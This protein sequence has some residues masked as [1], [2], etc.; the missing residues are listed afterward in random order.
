MRNV[1]KRKLAKHAC[2]SS[3]RRRRCRRGPRRKRRCGH[4]RPGPAV[5][6]G[7]GGGSGNGPAHIRR[8]V[9][10]SV[11]LEDAGGVSHASALASIGGSPSRVWLSHV[12][13]LVAMLRPG[14][15]EG[16]EVEVLVT[17]TR[18]ASLANGST[19]A[20]QKATVRNGR[21][22]TCNARMMLAR[23]R[24]KENGL[25]SALRLARATRSMST[26]CMWTKRGGASMGVVGGGPLLLSWRGS[27][28]FP[29]LFKFSS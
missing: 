14:S 28:C 3:N 12:C 17:P 23:E 8:R 24:P 27:D 7:L 4:G 13:T 18:R 29:G 5:R 16:V 10:A 1:R 20:S 19:P 9:P 22:T 25:V 6:P 15:R 21:S 2:G 26:G 11:A